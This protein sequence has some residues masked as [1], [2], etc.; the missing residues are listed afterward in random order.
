VGKAVKAL[1]EAKAE[2]PADP[3]VNLYL[4]VAYSRLGQ[5]S[6]SRAARAAARERAPFGLTPIE[7]SRLAESDERP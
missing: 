1:R 3:R 5:P 6:A 4:A 2:R 7:R